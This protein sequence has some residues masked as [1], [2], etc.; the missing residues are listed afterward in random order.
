MSYVTFYY[1]SLY[2]YFMLNYSTNI[3]KTKVALLYLHYYPLN[4]TMS[5]G[6]QAFNY[7]FPRPYLILTYSFIL[8]Y[9]S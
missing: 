1:S 9:R 6:T 7:I 2:K 5:I 3:V 4:Y 8:K